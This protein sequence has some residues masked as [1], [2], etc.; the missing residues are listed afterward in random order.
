MSG[1]SL[2]AL[3]GARFLSATYF[4]K[5]TGPCEPCSRM[6]EARSAPAAQRDARSRRNHRAHSKKVVSFTWGMQSASLAQI[7]GARSHAMRT[8]F[9]LNRADPISGKAKLNAAHIQLLFSLVQNLRARVRAARRTSAREVSANNNDS[10]FRA[11]APC[12]FRRWISSN[13]YV[14]CCKSNTR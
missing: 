2:T 3:K 6:E 4:S 5:G 7:D 1:I 14:C 13:K 12:W 9:E 11:S 8:L 10:S